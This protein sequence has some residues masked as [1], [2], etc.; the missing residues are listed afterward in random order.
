MGGSLQKELPFKLFFKIGEASK[1]IGVEPYVLRFWEKEFPFLR[2]KKTKGGQRLFT[3]KEIELLLEIK[4][5]LYEEKYTIEGVRKKLNKVYQ[6]IDSGSDIR[7]DILE[8]VRIKLKEILE[9]L[10]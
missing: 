4:K 8:K 5:M 3:K 9:I 10:S 7:K 1:I 2:L 6:S